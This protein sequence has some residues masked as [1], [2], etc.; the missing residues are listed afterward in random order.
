MLRSTFPT[1]EF[2]GVTH[3]TR[4]ELTKK[5]GTVK[6]W[7]RHQLSAANC[8]PS[9]VTVVAPDVG[10]I[11]GYAVVTVTLCTKLNFTASVVT[12]PPMCSFSGTVCGVDTFGDAHAA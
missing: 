3:W 1:L 10:P 8:N 2:G 12:N 9:T 7:N 6:S 5:A 11:K 4:V